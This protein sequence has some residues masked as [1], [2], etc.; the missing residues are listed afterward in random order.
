MRKVYQ[1]EEQYRSA[2]VYLAL[3]LCIR[4]KPPERFGWR[5]YS[6]PG[7]PVETTTV[8]V[9]HKYIFDQFFVTPE[10]GHTGAEGQIEGRN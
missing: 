1:T 7:R 6:R 2:C 10:S 4:T 3:K 8:A 9:R 5:R